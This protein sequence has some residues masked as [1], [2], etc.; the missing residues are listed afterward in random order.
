MSLANEWA[1]KEDSIQNPKNHCRSADEGDDM[2]DHFLGAR[3][4]RQKGQ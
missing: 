2:N 1:D 3:R 4:V